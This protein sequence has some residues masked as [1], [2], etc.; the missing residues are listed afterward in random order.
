[1][2]PQDVKKSAAHTAGSDH[3][4]AVADLPDL[5]TH[6]LC[7]A[8]PAR[9]TDYNGNR[10]NIRIPENCLQ[11]ND[12][13]QIG[14]AEQDF[15]QTHQQRIQPLRRNTAYTAEHN[16]NRGR[17]DRGQQS[18]KK[19]NPSAYQIIEK[20]SRPIVSVSKEELPRTESD[21]PDTIS[22]LPEGPPLPA[23]EYRQSGTQNPIPLFLCIP[24]AMPEIPL[25]DACKFSSSYHL[26][27][28]CH[29]LC[30][31]TRIDLFIHGLRQHI[32]ENYNDTG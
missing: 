7:N 19:G 30:P 11:Q 8:R 27:L 31:D 4:L 21:V 13:Q 32:A 14:H 28:F 2:S 6:N 17:N 23:F 9:H 18:D 10:H 24:G 29:L 22:F 25:P 1:M 20:I 15:R 16:R 3:V 26:R 12:K 5:R